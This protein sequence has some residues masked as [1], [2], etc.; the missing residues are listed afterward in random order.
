MIHKTV[1]MKILLL[2]FIVGAGFSYAYADSMQGSGSMSMNDNNMMNNSHM[3]GS[4][5]NDHMMGKNMSGGGWG[6]NNTMKEENMTMS[7]GTIDLSMASPVE[8]S[9]SAPVTIVEFGDYQCPECDAW[10]KNQDPAIKTNYIDT[11][12]VK[13]YFV[14]FPWAGSDSIS[15]A[16]ASYCA[17]DQGKYWDYHNYLYQ[18][19]AGIQSG[20]ANPSNLKSYAAILGLDTNKFNSCLDSGIYA[21]RVSHNK[22]V[23]TTKGVSGTPTFFIVGQTGSMQEIVGAQPASVFS[24]V[25]DQASTQTTPEFGPVVALVLAIAIVSI[26]AV[27]ART[28][29]RF[30][31][32]Q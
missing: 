32:R 22:D 14:D 27:S 31:P 2:V 29:I 1:M 19:Q 10:F 11:N 5:D 21:D 7:S 28:G 20:W 25:I 23:G 6:S 17:G 24:T 26:I 9:S 3:S 4:M 8:G 18:Q 16:E 30:I 13:L 15:A 12:K